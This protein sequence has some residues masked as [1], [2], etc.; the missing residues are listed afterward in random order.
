M[1]LKYD[2]EKETKSIRGGQ[3]VIQTSLEP[4]TSSMQE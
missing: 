1:R 4:G 2:H 3:Q